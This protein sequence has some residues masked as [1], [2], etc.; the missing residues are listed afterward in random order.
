MSD[1]G[2]SGSFVVIDPDGD[3]VLAVGDQNEQFQVSSQALSKASPVFKATFGPNFREG[4]QERSSS[5]PAT[6]ELPEDDPDG[7]RLICL[8]LHLAEIDLDTFG[9]SRIVTIRHAAI[10]I[11]KYQMLGILYWQMHGLLANWLFENKSSKSIPFVIEAVAAAYLLASRDTFQVA[12]AQ[13][14]K[15]C[16]LGLGTLL[17]DPTIDLLPS[18]VLRKCWRRCCVAMLVLTWSESDPG[19]ETPQSSRQKTNICHGLRPVFVVLKR[20]QTRSVQDLFQ[21]L[22]AGAHPMFVSAEME[23]APQ[24][25]V[26]SSAG[27]NLVAHSRR[28]L[29]QR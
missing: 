23:R 29:L 13:L 20:R 11:Q 12:T 18:R 10:A 15:N 22:L 16:D 1:I 9:R 27:G 21:R 4:Q 7:M 19:G 17:H 24:H 6:I 8:F 26:A 5:Q 28:H 14:V 25:I 3:V 2:S